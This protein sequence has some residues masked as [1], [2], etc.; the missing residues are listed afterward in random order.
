MHKPA[1]N[2]RVNQDL[3]RKSIP[4][5]QQENKKHQTIST[6][7]YILHQFCYHFH[8]QLRNHTISTIGLLWFFKFKLLLFTFGKLNLCIQST[9][10][11]ATTSSMRMQFY[12]IPPKPWINETPK[13]LP[14]PEVRGLLVLNGNCHSSCLNEVLSAAA[15]DL[16]CSKMSLSAIHTAQPFYH[17]T[18]VPP[19]LPKEKINIIKLQRI[20]I[21]N[22]FNY[23][24]WNHQL[25]LP[26]VNTLFFFRSCSGDE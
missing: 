4:L 25:H 19:C 24:P 12:I 10:P 14:R 26:Q 2:Q 11:I 15:F 22:L 9:K 7:L 23:K 21:S 17:G 13:Y 1:A 3:C 16:E 18:L 20:G 8:Q 6:K 5:L